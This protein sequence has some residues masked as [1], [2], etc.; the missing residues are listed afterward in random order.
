MEWHLERKRL[1]KKDRNSADTIRI[2]QG[3]EK[4]NFK[5]KLKTGNTQWYI[6][7]SG[8]RLEQK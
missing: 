4:N 7:M 5:S 8:E 2:R 3:D 1:Q 6:T